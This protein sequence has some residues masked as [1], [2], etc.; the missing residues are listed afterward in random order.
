VTIFIAGAG[1]GG[2]TAALALLAD[3]QRVRVFERAGALTEAGA[4]LTITPNASRVLES[5]GLGDWIGD[6]ADRPGRGE[7]RNGLTGETLAVNTRREDIESRFGAP[8]F[9][10]HRADL[11][12]ELA[13]RVRALD[14]AAISLDDAFLGFEQDAG[15]VGARFTRSG[16]LHADALVGADGVRSLVRDV[17]AGSEAPTFTGYVAWRGLVP[18]GAL[19]DGLPDP[20]SCLHLGPGRLFLR[21]GL[22]HGALVN[23]VSIESVSAWAEEGW[24][25]PGERAELLAALDGWHADVRRLVEAV[26]DGGLF[27]WGLFD[28]D[29]LPRW[30][31]GCVTLLGD[32]AHPMLP[33]LGQGAAMAIEDAAV[34]SRALSASADVEEALGRYEQARLGRANKGMLLSRENGLG[35]VT[36]P[37][38][39]YAPGAFATPASLGLMDYDPMTTP[40]G[41]ARHA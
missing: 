40:L 25:V 17:V 31:H 34:L 8:Y 22:R 36:Q 9:Q 37:S 12:A 29:P 33:F 3:G 2:L 4:G 27:K 24:S 23:F 39:A 30:S 20:P 5:L 16:D 18:A 21:Y 1:I 28:R 11:Q 32:A 13:A 6:V 35:L 10:V 14:P 19:Q 15:T 7:I 38:G 26:P 41:P